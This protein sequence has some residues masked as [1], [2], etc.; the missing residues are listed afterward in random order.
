[1]DTHTRWHLF[2]F[3]KK[4]RRHLKNLLLVEE[5]LNWKQSIITNV[6]CFA[7]TELVFWE[8]FY[9]GSS[10]CFESGR[11][12]GR[13][14]ELNCFW[15]LRGNGAVNLNE[16]EWFMG[17]SEETVI[18]FFWIF[19]KFISLQTLKCRNCVVKRKEKKP[20]DLNG[21]VLIKNACVEIT[22]L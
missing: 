21:N 12:F 10:F 9:F 7:T 5:S 13:K 6:N 17:T 11:Y 15:K 14:T 4:E 18:N 22:S 2:Q 3:V 19:E 1:M 20:F 8:K 16:D